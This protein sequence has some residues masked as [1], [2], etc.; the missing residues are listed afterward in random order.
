MGVN[1]YQPLFENTY[2]EVLVPHGVK[3]DGSFCE[4]PL[5]LL[6]WHVQFKLHSVGHAQF[7]AE[8]PQHQHSILILLVPASAHQH[9]LEGPSALGSLP[10]PVQHLFERPDLQTV[11][12]L[13]SELPDGNDG[14]A[15][16]VAVLLQRQ[17][18]EGAHVAR[19][20]DHT[21]AVGRTPQRQDVIQG[22]GGVDHDKIAARSGHAVEQSEQAVV[23]HLKGTQENAVGDVVWVVKPRRL[24]VKR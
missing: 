7:V 8:P 10:P 21:G 12:L 17:V 3:P 5:Q 19:R 11:I 4:F 13:R 15:L 9:Q 20:V 24:G 18:Q 1:E 16:P 23:D 22:P 6:E 2:S 14:A